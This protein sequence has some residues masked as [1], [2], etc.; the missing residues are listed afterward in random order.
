MY[1]AYYS[2]GDNP[3]RRPHH[4]SASLV[5]P[6]FCIAEPPLTLAGPR[7]NL[8]HLFSLLRFVKAENFAASGA[9]KGSR[10][11]VVKFYTARISIQNKHKKCLF[12]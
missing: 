12:G 3:V 8:S 9:K 6:F 10:T 11:E 7:F 4:H 2:G 1:S 5:P